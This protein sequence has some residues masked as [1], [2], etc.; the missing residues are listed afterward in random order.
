MKQRWGI[1]GLVSAISFFS[2]G[3]LLQRGVAGNGTV[4]QQARLFDDVMQHVANYYVDSL[5]EQ[6]LYK[7]ATSGM[8]EELK[9]PYS[10]LLTGDDY[11]ALTEQTSGN[12]AGLGI[13][14]DVRGGWITVVTPLP[15]TPAE[16]AGIE[17]GDQIIEVDGKS[18][19]GWKN[20]QA[21]KAL[22][23]EPGT[24]VKITVRRVGL[25]Q[26]QHY[27]LTRATIH[28]RSVPA[29]TLFDNG[30]G[31]ITVTTVS[32]SSADELRNEIESL[33]KKGMR[34]LVLN[35]R[36]NPGGLLDQGVKVADIFL[37]PKQEIV[38]TRGRAR[39]SSREFFDDAK[40]QWP[41]LPIVV[42]VNAGTASAA[43]IIAGALQD[44][45]RAV[46]VGTPT[47]GKGL[48]QTLFP[49]G[50]GTALKLTTARWYTPSGRT[51]QRTAKDEEDQALQAMSEG[52]EV[53][54]SLVAKEDTSIKARP[55]YRTD[56]GRVVR[57]GGGIVPDIV[58]R[59]DSLTEGEKQFARAIGDK[60]GVYRDVITG[61]ALEAKSKK[62]VHA[63]NFT[64]T[65]AMLDQVYQRLTTKGVKLTPQVFDSARTLV[66][67]Q[68]GYEIARYAFGQPAELRRRALD[69]P[70]MQMALKLLRQAQSPK[71][72]LTLAMS[73]PSGHDT[74]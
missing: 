66:G 23:G 18:T 22:R 51:I 67:Q 53:A 52:G 20:D 11:K 69:D 36:N 40:Q 34:T 27:E 50:E 55:A 16:R 41:D 31:Y 42:L 37:D 35:L 29:G 10:V 47:F 68:L 70:Q 24:K 7:R 25:Q 64:V 38:S 74:H 32:E 48:V 28:Q 26:V 63:E 45:D 49:L 59:P 56:A 21:V 2:G 6:E 43:E 13:Q 14:I 15:E 19:E 12:Y 54:D 46:V 17:S 72:L 58:V 33:R 8:L 4:L 1:I 73:Q 5:G 60:V 44:H 65:P 62:L 61:F 3:W 57:G 71:Q 30:V 39:G 9:D